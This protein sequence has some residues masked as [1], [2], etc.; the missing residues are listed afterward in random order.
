MSWGRS[1]ERWNHTASLLWILASIHSDP[2]SAN[3][4]QL[5]HYHPYLPEPKTPEMPPAMLA[6]LLQSLKR[7]PPAEAA[8]E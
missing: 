7:K 3:K 1:N 2:D 6:S 4:P 8:S 5:G